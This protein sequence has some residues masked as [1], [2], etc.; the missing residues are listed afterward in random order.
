MRNP[1]YEQ[2]DPRRADTRAH[3]R[4][5]CLGPATCPAAIE[6]YIAEGLR[7]VSGRLVGPAVFKA[8]AV[9]FARHLVGSIPIHSRAF[10]DFG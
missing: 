9:P 1:P 8:D 10:L 4:R 6:R 5:G 7:G 3:R 2:I